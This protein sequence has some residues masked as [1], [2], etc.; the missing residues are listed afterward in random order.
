MTTI[1]LITD[2][3]VK[4][5]RELRQSV[6]HVLSAENVE[7][8]DFAR[9]QEIIERKAGLVRAPFSEKLKRIRE[10]A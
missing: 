8:H 6:R 10:T 4:L 2:E 9:A 3:S 1:E 7:K 5:E